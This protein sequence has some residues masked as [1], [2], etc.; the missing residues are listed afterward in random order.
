MKIRTRERHLGLR[1]MSA[2]SSRYDRQRD[3]FGFLGGGW[4][5]IS[6]ASMSRISVRLRSR[7]TTVPGSDKRANAC[8]DSHSGR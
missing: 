2:E 4:G 6:H 8:G 1:N 5:P 7:V 3:V